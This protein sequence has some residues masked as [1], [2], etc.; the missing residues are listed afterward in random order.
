MAINLFKWIQ[1]K[2]A[3]D[4][5][6]DWLNNPVTKIILEG[7]R[8]HNYTRPLDDPTGPAALQA[9]GLNAGRD[10]TV[11]RQEGLLDEVIEDDKPINEGRMNNLMA[12]GFSSEEA[13]SMLQ[14]AEASEQEEV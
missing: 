13:Q 3:Q 5:Y 12:D 2:K 10:M 11:K 4:E 1:T 8:S 9:I 6:Q 14:E 7:S